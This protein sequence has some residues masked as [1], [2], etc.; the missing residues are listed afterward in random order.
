MSNK[1]VIIT[2]INP[3]TE[4]VTAFAAWPGWTT[5]VVGDRKSPPAWRCDSVVFLSIDE[6]A[7]LFPEFSALLPVN[8]YVRK[9]IGYLYPESVLAPGHT[10]PVT[11]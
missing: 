5:V 3:P 10:F 2:S 7:R 11:P 8:S 6:Q 1:F 4:A 9:M